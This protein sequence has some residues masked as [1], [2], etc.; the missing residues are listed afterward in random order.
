MVR[1]VPAWKGLAGPGG[2]GKDR[3]LRSG[4]VRFGSAVMNGGSGDVWS[5]EAVEA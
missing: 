1:R 2:Y 5:G 4:A 3:Q